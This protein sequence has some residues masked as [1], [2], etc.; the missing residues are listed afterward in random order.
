MPVGNATLMEIPVISVSESFVTSIVKVLGLSQ[1]VNSGAT[2]EE[3]ETFWA[4]KKVENPSNNRI[5]WNRNNFFMVIYF[6]K[7][8]DKVCDCKK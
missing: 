2:V 1:T 8:I 7:S 6:Y 5:R 4:F 3:I